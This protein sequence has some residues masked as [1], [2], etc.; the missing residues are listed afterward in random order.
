MGEDLSGEMLRQLAPSFLGP[1]HLDR[2]YSGGTPNQD[3]ILQ[4]VDLRRAERGGDFVD[5][6][7]HRGGRRGGAVLRSGV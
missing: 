3:I 7:G 6:A 5:V 1:S 4:K 2:A